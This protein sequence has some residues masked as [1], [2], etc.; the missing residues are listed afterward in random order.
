MGKSRQYGVFGLLSGSV[1]SVTYSKSKDGAGKTI[2]VV[3]AKPT[4]VENPNTI[5]QILQ[6]CKI[7]PAQRFYQAME[8]LLDHSWQG[9]A[10]M[11]PSR[12]Y[13]MSKAMKMSGPFVPKSVTAVI[14]ADYPIS[15]GTLPTLLASPTAA[16]GTALGTAALTAE[17]VAA[18]VAAGVPEGAQLTIVAWYQTSSGDYNFAYG[19]VINN[20]GQLFAWTGSTAAN[21][22]VTLS[23]GVFHISEA[24]G[25]STV[26]VG[27][28][29]S[30]L[31]NGK[32]ERS[33]Q[34][35]VLTD[36]FRDGLY[37]ATARDLTVESYGQ[38]ADI[39]RINNAWYLNLA[40]GQ[41]F[42][43][44]LAVRENTDLDSE[45]TETGNVIYGIQ[46]R[47][48]GGFRYCIFTDDGTAAGK[49]ML[50]ADGQIV[51]GT[52]AQTAYL[53][54][55]ESRLYGYKVEQWLDV[56]ATQLGFTMGEE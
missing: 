17:N 13:F 28:I 47:E 42:A 33:T 5:A 49:V 9:V 12:Q 26:S 36:T 18:L 22:T 14:P 21:M 3:K 39:N 11:Q 37:D 15:E 34:S 19:R 8:V 30:K 25:L 32:W 53:L 38:V 2:Q 44:Q 1:G 4:E 41:P 31:V 56:Y 50:V 54:S 29:C 45:G 52:A 46:A 10:Y 24:N 6:R 51:E 35:L 27:A 7:S 40:N 55:S 20:V 16:V 23:A 48:E 43:G